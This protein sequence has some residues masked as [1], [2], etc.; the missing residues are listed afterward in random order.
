MPQRLK[1]HSSSRKFPISIRKPTPQENS[2]TAR[3]RSSKRAL[4]S[5]PLPHSQNCMK[6]YYPTQT[7]SS[8]VGR[9]SLPLPIKAIRRFGKKPIGL[10]FFPKSHRS[11]P[12][13]FLPFRFS[14]LL[15]TSHLPKDSTWINRATLPK[16]SRW[17]DEKGGMR[18]CEEAEPDEA[19]S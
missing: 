19:I 1:H 13:P 2:S 9:L 18:H 12:L 3:F 10:C 16:A 5:F 4:S 15:I 11:F 7:K 6:K 8:A 14:F 17:S